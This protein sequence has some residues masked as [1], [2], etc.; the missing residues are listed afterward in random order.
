MRTK[1][2][3]IAGLLV[4]SFGMVSA[5]AG[6][7]AAVTCVGVGPV[8]GTVAAACNEAQDEAHDTVDDAR[9]TIGDVN[10]DPRRDT[11]QECIANTD[12]PICFDDPPP[13]LW[14]LWCGW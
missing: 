2:L 11:P 7:A 6:S 4:T 3:L 10:C 14:F 8:G 12:K 9:E 13:E 1:G 5:V